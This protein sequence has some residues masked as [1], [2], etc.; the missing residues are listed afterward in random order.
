MATYEIE[1][2]GKTFEVEAEDKDTALQALGLS[3]AS[4]DLT[5]WA[6]DIQGGGT[7]F[8]D[9]LLL[10]WGDEA[11]ALGRAAINSGVAG[12]FGEEAALFGGDFSKTYDKALEDTRDV[13]ERF[14]QQNPGV[15]L[16]TEIGGG[17]VGLGLGGGALRAAG[18]GGLGGATRGANAIRGAGIGT[19]E[20]ATYVLGENEGSLEDRY[21]D[22]TAGDALVAGL[23]T[24]AGAFGGSLT[25]GSSP[26]SRSLGEL[27]S[28]AGDK[29]IDGSKASAKAAQELGS[30]ISELAFKALDRVS[31]D[32][33]TTARTALGDLTD[34][35]SSSLESLKP[36]AKAA[37][38]KFDQYFQPVYSYA[39]KHV[40][41]D[42]GSRL[43]RGAIQG[44]RFSNKVDDLYKR[45][46][47]SAVRDAVE[48]S[49]RAMAAMADVAN[50][51]LTPAKRAVADRALKEEL[52]EDLHKNF[53]DF[54]D[55]QEDFLNE[56]SKGTQNV[57]RTH[58]YM[59][60][61]KERTKESG[62]LATESL[63]KARKGRESR[64]PLRTTDATAKDKTKLAR[65]NEDGSGLSSFGRDSTIMNPVDSH[66]FWLRSHGNLAEMNKMLGIRGAQTDEE[67]A[68]I[69]SGTFFPE[70]LR[71]KLRDMGFS[72]KR[73]EDAVEI[74]NQT[75]WGSQRAMAKELQVMRNLG[76]A[77]TLGNP[78][79]ALLQ[80]HDLF[81]AAWANGSGEVI[82]A[83]AKRNGF[84][85]TPGDVNLMNQIHG[86]VVQASRKGDKSWTGKPTIDWAADRSQKLMDW[87]MDKSQFANLD[88][89]TKGKIMSSALGREFKEV[90][91]DPAAWRNKWKG[92][93]DADELAELETALKNKDTG[94]D[95][96]KQLAMLNLS[97]L[98]PISAAN[99]SLMQLSIPNARILYMLKG[100]AMTQL[101]I[102]RRRIAANLKKP[103]GRKEALK[104]MMAY[105]LISGGG[106]G[107][108]NETRQIV[109]L[110]S[111]DYGNVPTLALYQMASIPTMGGFGGNQYGAHRFMQDP[112][113]SMK[114]NFVPPTPYLDG[115]AKDIAQLIQ[116]KDALPDKTLEA[117]PLIGPVLRGLNDKME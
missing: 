72:E 90:G 8:L 36:V 70:Q 20:G 41:K 2:D 94:N 1:V 81:N 13:E 37:G 42:F 33:A 69:A 113:G 30:D 19:A 117:L 52:G 68:Q 26:E 11:S 25:R 101:D 17:V 18:A 102:V 76:Y 50:S 96:V 93:F 7:T 3:G 73:A 39:Q 74:Y 114:D 31:P 112:M 35:A 43:R 29:V 32:A 85:I 15:S 66:H 65:L 71:T 89:W 14:R 45:T 49:P 44:T 111:P 57:K 59:S 21:W 108:V 109:K 23:G 64:E 12:L 87:A 62:D 103:N 84:D 55:Q 116:G 9:G 110:Q 34:V 22:L 95:L 28:I 77:T 79:G 47:M 88:R 106:Y 82:D 53:R 46:N 63:E 58:G 86:E 100:F 24:A 40:S 61:A 16:A 80:F 48:S 107:A 83:L 54:L 92:T 67:M 99:S 27:A 78:Y 75:V 51:N 38:Q 105:F 56:I 60:V 10:G 104:D 97:D 115:P 91:A 6:E 98:Q 4:P 5:T